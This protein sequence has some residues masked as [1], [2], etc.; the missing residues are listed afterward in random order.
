MSEEA[1]PVVPVVEVTPAAPAAT[2]SPETVTLTK[3]QHDQLARDA[4][5][6]ASN[7]RKAD[8]FDRQNDGKGTGH[9]P[10]AAPAAPPSQEDL[11][12]RADAEDKKAERGLIALAAN[13]A[14][15]E[16]L[17]AD[18]TLRDLMIKSPLAVL[19]LLA[20]DALDAE[21]ALNL[22][23]DAL[24]S[25]KPA[26]APVVTPPAPA[27]PPAPPAGAINAPGDQQTTDAVEK[28]RSN[29]NLE[30]AIAGMVTARLGN[31]K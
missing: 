15:R 18:P 2:P 12:A 4:A 29:P 6:A 17:D 22:V 9:F 24:N 20:P 13:P 10:A 8:L 27:T 26:P 25:R 23:K 30:H 14:F 7:Q 19:P 31:G 3:E 5:R 16:V 11:R 28:A 1:T 21:D